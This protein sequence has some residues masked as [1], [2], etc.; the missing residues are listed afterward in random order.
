MGNI[1]IN[2]F[3]G[4]NFD[5]KNHRYFVGDKHME[6]VTQC[7]KSKFVPEFD[8]IYHAERIA[9]REGKT[10]NEILKQWE[11]IANTACENGTS[12][13]DYAEQY[14]NYVYFEGKEPRS[15]SRQCKGAKKFIDTLPNHIIPVGTEI[16]MYSEAI[17]KAGTCDLLLL[18][19]ETGK[20]SFKLSTSQAL[21]MLKRQATRKCTGQFWQRW[22][23]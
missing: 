21:A 16:M 15:F 23:N 20:A 8:T 6:S 10:V 3:Q 5:K 14:V 2:N 12:V 9:K 1:R 17:N 4:L 7:I 13:H 18:N 22:M 19:N 11:K